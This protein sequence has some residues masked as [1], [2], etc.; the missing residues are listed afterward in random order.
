[1]K[2]QINN[3][4]AEEVQVKITKTLI[5]I[6]GK[7]ESEFASR[8][9]NKEFTIPHGV[10]SDTIQCTMNDEG[11][12]TLSAPIQQS[13]NTS[14]CQQT[15]QQRTKQQVTSS[16]SSNVQQQ[17][18]QQ[19]QQQVQQQQ[20]VKQQQHQTSHKMLQE[21]GRMDSSE[22]ITSTTSSIRESTSK[23]LEDMI[24]R[25]IM[26]FDLDA[27]MGNRESVFEDVSKQICHVNEGKK[28]EV[29]LLKIER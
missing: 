18:Q 15:Q 26:N 3:F 24:L 7:H 17:Q 14:V 2:I 16:V 6:E 1:M 11:V 9:F 10:K 29:S 25:P 23:R 8:S 12:L 21:T 5:K 20:Q 19:V 4:K 27:L 13:A 22:S 28:F